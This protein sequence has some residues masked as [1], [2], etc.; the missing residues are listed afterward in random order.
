[1]ETQKIPNF[2]NNLEKEEHNDRGII[3][4]DLKQCY[5]AIVLTIS[6][7]LA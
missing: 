2:Q 3:L 4:P 1:M 6:M 7:A 5:K